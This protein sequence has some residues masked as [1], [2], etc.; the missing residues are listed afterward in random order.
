MTQYDLKM[1]ISMLMEGCLLQGDVLGAYI[2]NIS[3]DGLRKKRSRNV[4]RQKLSTQR[5]RIPIFYGRMPFSDA[6]Q[7]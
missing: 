7:G 1:F 3:Y 2:I 4:S 5:N 6:K